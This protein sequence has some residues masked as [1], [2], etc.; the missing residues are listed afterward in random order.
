MFIDEAKIAVQLAHA[1][2]VPDLRA[3]PHRRAAT[4]S[5]WSTSGARTCSGSQNRLRKRKQAMP[6]PM[7]CLHLIA[8]VLRGARLRAPQARPAR[9]PARTRPPR[10]ARR[11]TSSSRTRAR[12]RSS[13][14][15]SPRRARQAREDAGRRAQGQVRL[16]VAR[17]GAR[18]CRSTAAATSSR[19][20]RCS[21]S[22]SPASA[23]SRARPT[24]RRSRRCA[25]STSSRRASV[26][27][28]IPEASSSSS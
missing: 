19:S 21:T 4:S 13:T 24:S 1:N 25:T 9:P 17:A 15:A 3:R 7:A 27:P 26:N 8:K 23:C 28:T 6:V 20:A 12:S 11:R 16:H 14:S 5:R 22:A 2:I 10:R 18:A